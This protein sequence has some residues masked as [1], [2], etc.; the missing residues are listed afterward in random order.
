MKKFDFIK[1]LPHIVAPI[2]FLII[3]YSYFS[4]LLEGK[5]LAQHD[6]SMWRGSAKE[7][8]DFRKDKGE[9]T[10]WTNSM[11]CGMPSYLI[12]TSFSGNLLGYANRVFE[13]GQRPA[14]FI[15]LTMI[16]FYVLLLVLGVNPWLSIV[17]GIAYGFSS[18]F[19]II[20]GAGHNAKIHAIGYVAPILAGMILSFRGKF[21]AGFALFGISL[22]LNLN[23][24]HPQ[25]TYYAGFIMIALAIAY[26]YNAYKEKLLV[27][28]GK[29]IAVLTIA[30][31]LAFGAN[32]SKLWFTYDYGKE[33]IRGKSELS[34]NSSDKTSGLDKSYATGWSYGVA[35]S[36]NLLIPNLM[37]GSTGMDIGTDSETYKFL[38]SMGVSDKQADGMV[39]QMYSY[40]GPQPG[41]SGPVYIGAIVIFLFFFALFSIKGPIKWALLAVTVLS[42]ALAMGSHF[43]S[44]TSFF[45]DYF[46]GYNKF[47]TV[48]MIL[49]IAEVTMPLLAFMAL[50]QLYDGA[51]DK[52]QFI[53]AFKWALGIPCAI[54][55]FFLLFGGAIF[56]FKGL[57][58]SQLASAGWPEAMLDA[59][60]D[61]RKSMLK[62]D[63]LRSLI[64]ILLSAG[65]LYAFY[66]KKLK[67]YYFVGILGLLI[68]ADMWVV[69]KRYMS[70]KRFVSDVQVEKPFTPTAA[71][72]E[73]L[74]DPTLNY[75]VLDLSDGLG[76][77]FNDATASYFHKSLGGYHG[78]KL[79]RYQELVDL[80]IARGNMAV[81]NMLN[82]RYVIQQGEA[83]PMAQFNPQA[84]GNAWFVDSVQIASNADA[85]IAALNN[86]N[87]ASKAIVDMRFSHNLEGLSTTY[88]T[89]GTINLVKYEPNRLVYSSDANSTKVAVFSE[90]Y[91]PRGWTVT[92][93]GQDA[94]HF[95]ANYILR[96][97]V[98][99]AGKHEIVFS[100][101][102]KM[103]GIGKGI[104]LA[105][106]LLL[107]LL[108]VGWIAFE[109]KK[110]LKEQSE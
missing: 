42:I 14:S 25:I 9:E 94:E 31:L 71:D 100:F 12:A 6:I 92:V 3:S 104:D 90:I 108:F 40:W 76:A 23:T 35:E 75:R 61:D 106:S 16:G 37:G 93:D 48:T 55:L 46:P 105:S 19:F 67:P 18:Y 66:N 73:I 17:G 82:T 91:Y 56:D 95:R 87:P 8:L 32:F 107:I 86:F 99:P 22:G 47:R 15:F 68:L 83:G 30:S 33:S 84:M 54:L 102:P 45:L 58:D 109:L 96:A 70:N 44:L 11:F 60:R 34:M 69:N 63:A 36:F 49:F 79:R 80:H 1:I 97:M 50:K 28:F 51:L 72:L 77:A 2:L 101:K 38:K 24:G 20:I 27:Q 98:V 7:V 13:L 53:I 59:F 78:A 41:T 65:A 85:E 52:K 110:V 57:V 21:V 10:L 4:P 5:K 81:L 29:A 89:I 64:Y 62:A 74:K 88:D 43:M 39:S 26:F 103:Y